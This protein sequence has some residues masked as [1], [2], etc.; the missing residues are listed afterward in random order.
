L[1]EQISEVRN[2]WKKN[3]EYHQKSIRRLNAKTRFFAPVDE[4]GIGDGIILSFRHRCFQPIK[5]KSGS[6]QSR[7]GN[8]W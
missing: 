1:A 8:S 4:S 3:H 7:R 5:G 2:S 6:D